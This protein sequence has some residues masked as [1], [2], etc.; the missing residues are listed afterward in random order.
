MPLPYMLAAS[1]LIGIATGYQVKSTLFKAK[2]SKELL[3]T[4]SQLKQ[5]GIRNKELVN[6]ISDQQQKTKIITKT[7]IKRI[8][9]YVTKKQKS[10]SDCNISGDAKRMLNKLVNM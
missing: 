2:Q 7:I 3:Q 5:V 4:V 10:D 6:E 8:P 9:N 1:L